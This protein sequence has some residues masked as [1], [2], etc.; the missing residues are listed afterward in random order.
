MTSFFSVQNYTTYSMLSGVKEPK[1][2]VDRATDLGYPA[3]GICDK[4]TLAGLIEFQEACLAKSVQ[5]ILGCEFLVYEYAGPDKEA[6]TA[7]KKI[8]HVLLYIKSEQGFKNLIYLNNFS[9]DPERGKFYRPRISL[10]LLKQYSE[11]LVCITPSEG[12]VG[13]QNE[14]NTLRLTKMDQL[15]ELSNIFRE[16]F[17]IGLNPLLDST[18]KYIYANE[19]LVKVVDHGTFKGIYGFNAHYP[20]SS[21]ANLYDV[22]RVMDTGR[23][24]KNLPRQVVNGTMPDLSEVELRNRNINSYFQTVHKLCMKSLSEVMEKCSY[25]I[26]TGIYHMP[27]IQ[28]ETESLEQDLIQ[29]IGEGFKLKLCPE[30]TFETLKSFDEL[31]E[32]NDRYP[33]EHI[34]KGEEPGT[35]NTLD[36]YLERLRYEYSVV[37]KMGFLDYFHIIHDIC[38]HN[39][40][41][42]PGRGSGSGSLLSYLLNITDV[43]PIRHG[44]IFER[45]LNQ[46]RKDLPDIDLDFSS[47]SV[48]I[49]EEY[50]K[51][52]YG[53]N[54]VAPIITYSRLK[55]ASAVKD[56][57]RA[58]SY[59]IPANDGTFTNY[60]YS[61]LNRQIKVPYV[62]ATARGEEELEERLQFTNFEEFYKKHSKWFIDVIMPLQECVVNDGIHAAGTIITHLDHDECLP[63]KHN[64]KNSVFVSQ[65]KDKD[66]EKRGFPK[67]DFLT[68]DALDVINR[69]RYLIKK[70]HGIDVPHRREIPLND[71]GALAVFENVETDGIFQFNTYA[72]KN[73][74]LKMKPK[75]FDDA[76]A[77]VA[78]VR[79]G[80]MLEEI[81]THFAE[82]KN[83]ER[84][85][86]YD[87]EDLIP[88]LGNTYGFMIYQEQMMSIVREIGGLT[89]VEAEKVRRAC[90]KKKIDEMNKWEETFKGGAVSRGY[91]AELAEKLWEKIVKFAEYSFNKCLT[92]DTIVDLP[93]GS[94][95][96]IEQLEEDLSVAFEGEGPSQLLQIQ[97][98]Q[99]I[100]P[101]EMVTVH[102]NGVKP[103]WRLVLE[104]GFSVKSTL[105]HRFL[106]DKGYVELGDMFHDTYVIV[107]GWRLLSGPDHFDMEMSQV[108]SI[109][110]VGEEM[111]YDVEMADPCHNFIANGI[112]SHNSHAA[113]Y[114]LIS[115]EQAYIKSRWP[116]EYW[117]ASMNFSST[118]IKKD[119]SAVNTKYQAVDEGIE[120]IYPNIF[121]FASDFE[122]YGDHEIIWP[123]KRIKG[124]GT[125]AV[126]SICEGDRSSFSSI[127]EMYESVNKRVVNKGVFNALITAG[128]FDPICKPW[129]AAAEYYRLRGEEV[130]Y[131]MAHKNLYRWY[132]LKNEA[133]NMIVTPW[134]DL[135]P[136]HEK[137]QRLQGVKLAEKKDGSKVFIGGYVEDLKIRQTKGGKWYAACKIVDDGESHDVKFWAPFWG[138]ETLDIEGKRPK[139]GQVVELIGI[140]DSW[141]DRHQVTINDPDSYVKI[142]WDDSHFE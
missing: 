35:L 95:I 18:S 10:E 5:P 78:L 58:Y 136:F 38:R 132:K 115:Y 30:A 118:D 140:K 66:C 134:K 126:E 141:N 90:G 51:N 39:Q 43:D 34:F 97:F 101:G 11:G 28:L 128:F 109:E 69:A 88:I 36:V 105:N 114:S 6:R 133:F 77:A 117:A 119:N 111:T 54:R 42:A 80:P 45:F 20:I 96:S 48:G 127:E 79:P 44:L 135:A 61:N 27:E 49:T 3:L 100:R 4:Q 14:E 92:G 46:D 86:I 63:L 15:I 17:Y 72:Q 104:N 9:H 93:G 108:F 87:H 1:Y 53:T 74:L 70:R 12:G 83:G 107:K 2:W 29:F 31:E 139:N 85:L 22:L 130:P 89:G 52:K 7:A 94:Q 71:P 21:E 137:V 73:Y 67:L 47:A 112:V 98:D 23:Q 33:H 102:K 60:D 125:K 110:Y 41:R 19:A 59:T 142:V 57:A 25:I 50:V 13:T 82:V 32:Y 81:H 131:E 116:Q 40:D 99:I 62:K 75:T 37:E 8:G 129:E 16:D 106:T 84:A 68:I 26:P 103:V 121:A 91:E 56:I 122:P 113:S 138:N 55:V 24:P 124:L 120:F 64:S 65:W 123:L 76:V